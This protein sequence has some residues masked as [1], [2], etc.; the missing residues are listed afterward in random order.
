MKVF[1]FIFL[2][3]MLIGMILGLKKGFFGSIT[4]P[5]KLIASVCLTIVIATP[6]L[7]AWTR[8]MFTEK[9]ESWI[10]DSLVESC[11]D[12]EIENSIESL[13]TVL[14]ILAEMSD[15]DLSELDPSAATEEILHA[16]AEDLAVP[17]GN[18]IAVL[19]TYAAL[20]LILLI[21]IGIL[22]ALLDAIFTT[23]WLGK[24]NKGL[25]LLLGAVVTTVICCVLASIVSAI[26]DNAVS[27]P[28]SQ[29]FINFNPFSLIFK[30]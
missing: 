15:V 30:I 10:Y 11:P 27:G 13:P 4:K 18:L 20:F 14:K 25:G 6:I 29:F 22:V 21:L 19:I 9:A 24:I 23:G 2:A 12:V 5:I 3:I 28:I 26:S 7:N 8:P 17:V 1:D 16:I